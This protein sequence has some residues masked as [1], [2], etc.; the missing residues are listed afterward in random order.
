MVIAPVPVPAPIPVPD[1]VPPPKSNDVVFVYSMT[2]AIKK[3]KELNKKILVFFHAP[4]CGACETMK[5][6]FPGSK[7]PNKDVKTAMLD[8]V[9]FMCNTDVDRAM[10]KKYGIYG[11]PT[12]IIID[13]NENI[14]KSGVGGLPAR[15]FISWLNISKS[16]KPKARF[17]NSRR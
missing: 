16:T 1:T 11:L 12:Y 10:A 6:Y 5:D 2:D 17:N 9:V 14:I 3:S 13:E 4:W 7:H 8:Y 15:Q